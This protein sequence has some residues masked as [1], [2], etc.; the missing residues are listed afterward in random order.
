[1]NHHRK[2]KARADVEIT[3]GMLSEAQRDLVLC[4]N[5]EPHSQFRPAR[6]GRST[7]TYD[8]LAR[9]HLQAEYWLDALRFSRDGC[10]AYDVDTDNSVYTTATRAYNWVIS[11]KSHK[12]SP[13]AGTDHLPSHTDLVPFEHWN[14]AATVEVIE[15]FMHKPTS[16]KLRNVMQVKDEPPVF[17][18]VAYTPTAVY[19]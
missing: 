7:R 6:S 15:S 9:Y 13:V 18:T 8:L 4:Y 17:F 3:K 5:E 10:N 2:T 16:A 12:H 11:H 19:M 14:V 1:M